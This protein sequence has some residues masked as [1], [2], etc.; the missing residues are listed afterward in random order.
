MLGKAKSR[1]RPA[2]AACGVMPANVELREKALAAIDRALIAR[3]TQRQALIQEAVLLFDA[4]RALED[5]TPVP[6]PNRGAAPNGAR[7]TGS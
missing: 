1:R 5:E 4:A 6:D 7:F 2:I 3:G